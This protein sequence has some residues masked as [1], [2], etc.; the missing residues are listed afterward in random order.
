MI[1]GII[2]T[3]LGIIALWEELYLWFFVSSLPTK[4]RFDIVKPKVVNTS[5]NTDSNTKQ[6]NVNQYNNQSKSRLIYPHDG[7]LLLARIIVRCKRRVNQKQ[8]EP[9]E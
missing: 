5:V 7:I 8:T 3:I 9:N 2:L 1:I 4:K 6:N